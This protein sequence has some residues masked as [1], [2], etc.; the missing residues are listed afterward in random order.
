MDGLPELIRQ[1]CVVIAPGNRLILLLSNTGGPALP[2]IPFLLS[3][4]YQSRVETPLP[5]VHLPHYPGP[6]LLGPTDAKRLC[7]NDV[8]LYEGSLGV[9]GPTKYPP[10]FHNQ[11]CREVAPYCARGRGIPAY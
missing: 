7:K 10:P 9:T 11:D 5:E 8:G 2:G 6:Y 4:S 1:H 3:A